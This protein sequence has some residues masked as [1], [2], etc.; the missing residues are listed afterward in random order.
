LLSI[1]QGNKKKKKKVLNFK[2]PIEKD[3][4]NKKYIKLNARVN[5]KKKK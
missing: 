3:I 5:L 1:R 2:K 4:F